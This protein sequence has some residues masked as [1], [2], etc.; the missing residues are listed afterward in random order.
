MNVKYQPELG[1]KYKG[2]FVSCSEQVDHLNILKDDKIKIINKN[3]SVCFVDENGQ[4]VGAVIRNAATQNVAEH[5]G[6]KI[7]IMVNAHPPIT[8]GASHKSEGIIVGQGLR[9]NP[10]NSF[11]GEYVYKKK[12]RSPEKQRIYDEGGNSLAKWLYDNGRKYFPWTVHSYEEFKK[13]VQLE[14]NKIIGAIFGAENYESVGHEDNDRS[15]FAIAYSYEFGVVSEGYFFYPDYGVAIEM[16]SNSIWCW[17]T[18]AIHGT[19]KLNLEKGGTRYTAAVT[20][21]E[22][23]ARA[24]ERQFQQ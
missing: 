3:L 18:K 9:K 12:A 19:A 5:F 2:Q 16:S 20:L 24:I 11:P 17:K 4:K 14:D 7:K 8:R 10:E 6:T 1:K 13:K 21:T 22:K 15:E 23:T